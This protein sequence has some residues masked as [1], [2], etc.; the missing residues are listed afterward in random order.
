[1]RLKLKQSYYSDDN[2]YSTLFFSQKIVFPYAL[3]V[4][5]CDLN[6]KRVSLSP[7]QNAAL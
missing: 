5:S 6:A 7:L 1:M 3:H 4:I 2:S